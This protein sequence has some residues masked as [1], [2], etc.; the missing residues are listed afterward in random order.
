VGVEHF[1]VLYVTKTCEIWALAAA[2]H[3]A[4]VRCCQMKPITPTKTV[5]VS[6]LAG[7]TDP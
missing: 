2:E 4:T 3:A 7:N 1:Y 5:G 6:Q